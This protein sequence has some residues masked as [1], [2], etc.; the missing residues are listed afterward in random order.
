[1]RGREE[2]IMRQS[3]VVRDAITA[4]PPLTGMDTSSLAFLVF[5]K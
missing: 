2:V 4:A 5:R 3:S 1:M